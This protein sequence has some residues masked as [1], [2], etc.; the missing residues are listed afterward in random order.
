MVLKNDFQPSIHL[1]QAANFMIADPLIALKWA[2]SRENPSSRVCEQHWRRPACALAQ[3]DQRLCYLC[4]GKY[5][6]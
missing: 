6:I 1:F 2:L 4:F 5:H 3:S